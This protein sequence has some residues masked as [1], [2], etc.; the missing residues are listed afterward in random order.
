MPQESIRKFDNVESISFK[1][2]KP[3]GDLIAEKARQI[4]DRGKKKKFADRPLQSSS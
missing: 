4:E 2:K 1:K 3:G